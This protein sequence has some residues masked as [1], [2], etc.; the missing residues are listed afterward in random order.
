MGNKDDSSALIRGAI[1]ELFGVFCLTYTGGWAVINAGSMTLISISVAHGLVL[2]FVIFIGGSVSGGHFNPAVT[3]P[4]LAIGE[5]A[6]VKAGIWV[7]AQILGSVMGGLMIHLLSPDG[8]SIYGFPT[9]P[10]AT[11]QGKGFVLEMIATFLLCY[12]VVAGIRMGKNEHTIGVWVGMSLC[13]AINSIGPMTG[14]SLNPC[15]TFGPAL[16]EGDFFRRGWWL[17]YVGTLLGGFLG[18][19]FANFVTHPKPAPKP[20]AADRTNY[21]V[22]GPMKAANNQA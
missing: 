5:V 12:A 17:Y 1:M 11:T 15:R 3:L 22:A 9:L 10:A 7:L 8:V 16:F 18:C 19:F 2:A 6:P 20:I 21:Q 4:L 14:A 13:L